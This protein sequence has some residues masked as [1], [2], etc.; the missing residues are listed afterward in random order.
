MFVF[1]LTPLILL[2]NSETLTKLRG[3][4]LFCKEPG[5]YT[6][7][8]NSI[9]LI[10]RSFAIDDDSNDGNHNGNETGW[11]TRTRTGKLRNQDTNRKTETD[12]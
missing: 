6:S 1:A 8:K 12:S 10:T 4:G 9:S 11:K 3:W 7:V 5:I 2:L